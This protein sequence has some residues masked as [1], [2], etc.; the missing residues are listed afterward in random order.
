MAQPR[1]SKGF[2]LSPD[3]MVQSRMKVVEIMAQANVKH[4]KAMI[5]DAVLVGMVGIVERLDAAVKLLEHQIIE[6]ECPQF[7]QQP[8]KPG[9]PPPPEDLKDLF[10]EEL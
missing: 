2:R 3:A 5:V 9:P 10:G 8:K 4:S 7:H 1:P 6:H